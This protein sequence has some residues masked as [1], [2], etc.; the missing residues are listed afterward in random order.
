MCGSG[1]ESQSTKDRRAALELITPSGLTS[2][3]EKS[4]LE[5][6]TDTK[7]AARQTLAA[8]LGVQQLR[9]ALLNVQQ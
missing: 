6:K 3:I 4:A 5:L 1:A 2:P 9:A 7:T 8:R